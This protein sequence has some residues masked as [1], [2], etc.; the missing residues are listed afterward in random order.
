MIINIIFQYVLLALWGFTSYKTVVHRKELPLNL[1]GLLLVTDILMIYIVS[2]N[3][4]FT[5]YT[6][7]LI[8]NRY[9]WFIFDAL[10]SIIILKIINISR[11]INHTLLC[12]SYNKK[13]NLPDD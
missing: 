4:T 13:N 6:E 2:T 7:S 1:F 3:L 9:E 8:G 12:F 11:K 5:E 10:V